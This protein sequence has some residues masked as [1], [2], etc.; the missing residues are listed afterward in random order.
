MCG[1]SSAD[2][3][4]SFTYNMH[5]QYARMGATLIHVY[6]YMVYAEINCY[7]KTTHIF[8]D[9]GDVHVCGWN[10]NGQLGLDLQDVVNVTTFHPITSL[11]CKINKVSCGW[12]HTMA[13]GENG[14]VFVWG[15]NAFGQL[16]EPGVQ[17]QSYSPVQLS[18]EVC[19]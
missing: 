19:L 12:N 4:T 10:K 13:L 7:S 18:I 3:Y 17:K 15:S 1:V 11:P 16:G 8:S 9:D 5:S 14:A 2:V 6:T